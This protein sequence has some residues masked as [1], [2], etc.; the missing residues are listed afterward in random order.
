[1]AA[2]YSEEEEEEILHIDDLQAVLPG[3]AGLLADMEMAKPSEILASTTDSEAWNLEVERVAP[4]LK[5]TVRVDGRDWR[6][7]L[8]QVS[9]IC[10]IFSHN[11]QVPFFRC[12]H[13]VKVSKKL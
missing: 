6:S 13:I 3:N 8:E 1:M 5:V 4:K 7:H 2:E 11:Y 10:H 12:I 9:H